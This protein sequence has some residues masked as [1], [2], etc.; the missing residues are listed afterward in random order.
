MDLHYYIM[1]NSK[2][3][4]RLSIALESTD[5]LQKPKTV[6]ISNNKESFEELRLM[7][8]NLIFGAVKESYIKRLSESAQLPPRRLS[9]EHKMIRLSSQR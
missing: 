7:L 5:A 2:K 4:E 6:R 9:S 8:N 3:K 1:R